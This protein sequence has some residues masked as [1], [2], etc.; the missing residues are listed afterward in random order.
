MKKE[1]RDLLLEIVRCPNIDACYKESGCVCNDIVKVQKCERE[2][3]S[4]PEPWN[5]DLEN[6]KILFVSSNPSFNESENYP[7][8]K[9]DDEKIIEFF[10]GRFNGKYTD[11]RKDNKVCVR[12]VDGANG[13]AEPYWGYIRNR[14]AELLYNNCE[15]MVKHGEDYCLTEVVHCKSKNEKGLNS[16]VISECYNKY[17]NR[18]VRL[19]NC[20]VI[21]IVGN[22]AFRT[23]TASGIKISE[24]LLRK[25]DKKIYSEEVELENGVKKLFTYLDAPAAGEPLKSF[26]KFPPEEFEKIKSILL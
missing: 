21:I 25:G 11:V 3:F 6:A 23:L 4:V 26:M 14:T 8:M 22:K 18:L 10:D 24:E 15:D 1:T 20:K 16:S 12:N 9:W 2:N 17:F 19:S 5:G 13:K 7:E